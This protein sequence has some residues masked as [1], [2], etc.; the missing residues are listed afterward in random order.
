MC[1]LKGGAPFVFGRGGEEAVALAEA[2]VPFEVVP[3]VSSAI[4]A[5]AYAGIPVTYRG[6]CSAL[7]II[8]GHGDS[9]GQPDS[10]V[11]RHRFAELA[12]G[13]DTLV[14]LMGIENLPRIVEGLVAGG[15]SP[16]TPVALIRWGTW[17]A[18]E[19]LVGTL[20][21]IADQAREA[22]FR[23][24]AVTVVGEVVNLREKIRWFDNR[25]L[26]G[27]RGLRAPPPAQASPPSWGL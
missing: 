13:L 8:A 5:P 23:A 4:G 15:R 14:F 9:H 7:G 26:F 12:Q 3:G 16:E 21:T 11:E 20:A 27:R 18:Q 22:R 17:P 6:V 19:T 2:G 10:A 24:P 25:P 1:R